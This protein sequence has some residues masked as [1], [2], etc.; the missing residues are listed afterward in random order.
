MKRIDIIFAI[1][2]G[3]AVAWIVEDF[4]KG[5]NIANH[6]KWSVFIILPII[7]LAGLWIV[8]LIGRK[9][10]FI[11]QAGKYCLVGAFSAVVDIKVFQFSAWLFAFFIILSPLIFKIISFLAD[12]VARYFGN[13]YWTF[14]KKGKDGIKKEAV[15]FLAVTLVGLLLNVAIFYYFIKIMQPQFYLSVKIWT[16]LSIILAAIGAA[17]WNF[18]SCKFLV[19]KK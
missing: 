10:L 16:E 4:L 9:L 12:T 5:Y 15:G 6:Y 11:S 1:I 2:C 14:E 17:A 19:F 8:D 18:L 7:S 13:K 3:L